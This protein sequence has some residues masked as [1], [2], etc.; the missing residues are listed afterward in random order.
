MS[1][2]IAVQ[3]LRVGLFVHLDLGWME[4]PFPLSSFRI[5]SEHDLAR[6]R[7]PAAGYLSVPFDEDVELSMRLG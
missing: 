2:T 7:S 6:V 4:H 1:S 5:E 3:D